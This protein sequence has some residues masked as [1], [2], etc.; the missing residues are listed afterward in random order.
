MAKLRDLFHKVGNCHNKI[1]FGAGLA[2]M[3]LERASKGNN[4]LPSEI[5]KVVGKLTEFEQCA[6][7]ATEKLRQ[8]KDI[9]DSII[10]LDTDK[11]K[12]R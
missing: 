9:V 5:K 1:C 10:D 6:S 3:V 7:E 4:P 11:P 12:V 8:I 2:K